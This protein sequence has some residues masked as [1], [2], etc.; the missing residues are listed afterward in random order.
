M[1]SNRS[2]LE[3]SK[4]LP[5]IKL[6][7]VLDNIRSLYNVGSMF[8]TADAFGL[9]HLYLC[10]MTGAPNSELQRRRI[11]KTSLG[12]EET[13][14][15]TKC[16]NALDAVRN[17]KADGFTVVALEQT[18]Q[19]T[20]LFEFSTSPSKKIALIVGHELYGVHADVLAAADHHLMIPMLG[21]KESL[22]VAVAFG[23]ATAIL[24]H[25]S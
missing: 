7:G 10:G 6:V 22:N 14:P 24:R 15:W 23:I 1:M 3:N 17:L 11:A 12:A 2:L 5:K 20:S 18:P 19:A 8:R 4:S 9:K 21:S 16:E 25:P 13:V